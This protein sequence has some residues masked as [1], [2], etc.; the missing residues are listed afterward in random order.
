MRNA[1]HTESSGPWPPSVL[2]GST[3]GPASWISVCSL[4]G[5]PSGGVEWVTTRRCRP[6]RGAVQAV[7]VSEVVG[8]RA[9]CLSLKGTEV[10]VDPLKDLLK[11]TFRGVHGYGASLCKRLRAGVAPQC[12]AGVRLLLFPHTHTDGWPFVPHTEIL[13]ALQTQARVCTPC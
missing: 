9:S 7:A 1:A 5:N 6:N 8:R 11:I 3:A 2:R 10:A 4:S 13:D 12:A